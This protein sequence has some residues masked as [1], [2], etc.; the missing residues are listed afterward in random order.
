MTTLNI[1]LIFPSP[2]PEI[3][4]QLSTNDTIA[5]LI[6]RTKLPPQAIIL[7]HKGTALLK[8]NKT[9]QEY[10]IKDTDHIT[11]NW[12]HGFAY[13]GDQI[14]GQQAQAPGASSEQSY[15][16]QKQQELNQMLQGLDPDSVEYQVI[17]PYND[18]IGSSLLDHEGKTRR[19]HTEAEHRHSMGKCY[20][21]LS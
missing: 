13:L 20:G 19:S 9:L 16:S 6:A 7:Y 4:L 1:T 14:K 12:R 17:Q 2:L 11:I 21:I 5:S 15:E 8:S 10:N 3:P 18:L